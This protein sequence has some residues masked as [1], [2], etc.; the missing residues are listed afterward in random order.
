MEKSMLLYADEI[1]KLPNGGK[2]QIQMVTI[3]L[4]MRTNCPDKMFFKIV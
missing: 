3:F 2:Y 1:K 4:K